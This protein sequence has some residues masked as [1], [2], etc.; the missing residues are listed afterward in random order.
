MVIET[1]YDY[2][3]YTVIHS[4]DWRRGNE[5]I[6]GNEGFDWELAIEFIN[7]KLKTSTDSY[8]NN[9]IVEAARYCDDIEHWRH[10]QIQHKDMP[11]FVQFQDDQPIITKGEGELFIIYEYTGSFTDY[12]Q[13]QEDSY[14]T[15]P[16]EEDGLAASGGRL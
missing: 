14:S 9:F 13:D 12:A 10:R 16:D 3:Y 8:I 7:H 6:F 2:I 4:N 1:R 11:V 15:G 5:D